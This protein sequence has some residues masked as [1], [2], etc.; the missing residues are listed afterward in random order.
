MWRN[1]EKALTAKRREVVMT[2]EEI[3]VEVENNTIMLF[4]NCITILSKYIR[5]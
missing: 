4:K 2:L 1:T 3:P 5:K